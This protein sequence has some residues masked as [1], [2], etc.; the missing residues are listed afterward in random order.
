M[1]HRST[2]SIAMSALIVAAVV[3]GAGPARAEKEAKLN[4]GKVGIKRSEEEFKGH[5]DTHANEKLKCSINAGAVGQYR[6]STVRGIVGRFVGC[7]AP[8]PVCF[9]AAQNEAAGRKAFVTA[10]NT[11]FGSNLD[12]NMDLPNVPECAI[13][14]EKLTV[15]LKVDVKNLATGVKAWVDFKFGVTYINA[16]KVSFGDNKTYPK[17]DGTTYPRANG[18]VITAYTNYDR[19]FSFACKVEVDT[20]ANDVDVDLNLDYEARNIHYCEATHSI[21]DQIDPPKL[22]CPKP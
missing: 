8:T 18:D 6:S 16:Q 3:A 13:P 19:T 14:S 12:V 10:L 2:K 11:R 1:N 22:D 5:L 20:V 21:A 17:L 15:T 4:A 7:H 9:H